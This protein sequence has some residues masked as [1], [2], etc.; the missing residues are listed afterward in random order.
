MK[1]KPILLF[2][3][4]TAIIFSSCEGPEGDPG[5]ANVIYSEWS[6]L[7]GEWRDSTFSGANYKVNHLN[8]PAL[9]QDIIDMRFPSVN[10]LNAVSLSN[11]SKAL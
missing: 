7:D 9:T 5:T 11:S 2:A 3:V 6:V 1:T 8:A 4:F 10:D